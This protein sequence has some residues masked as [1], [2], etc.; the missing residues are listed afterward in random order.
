MTG[1]FEN[2]KRNVKHRNTVT[3]LVLDTLSF[4]EKWIFKR[5]GCIGPHIQ[6]VSG[7]ESHGP[8]QSQVYP[9]RQLESQ[10]KTDREIG[11]K[12][13]PGR[14]GRE[15]RSNSQKAVGSQTMVAVP[16]F[17]SVTA[18]PPLHLESKV[19]DRAAEPDLIAGNNTIGILR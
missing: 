1:T 17:R 18:E 14:F 3:V 2:V 13:I 12:I 11:G 7:T 5:C 10:S 16:S 8:F 4:Y 19:I 6:P 9:L 15:R